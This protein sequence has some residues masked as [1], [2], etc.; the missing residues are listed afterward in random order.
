MC[1]SSSV[2]KKLKDWI[3]V[4]ALDYRIS[5]GACRQPWINNFMIEGPRADQVWTASGVEKAVNTNSNTGGSDWTLGNIFFLLW[6]WLEQVA[7]RSCGVSLLGDTQK[8]SRHDIC[9]QA[10]CVPAWA[11]RLDQMSSRGRF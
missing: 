11:K 6:R 10:L 4:L 3:Y 1:S 9:Q 7:E 5:S 2:L 8:P